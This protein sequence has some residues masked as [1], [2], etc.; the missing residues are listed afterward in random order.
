MGDALLTLVRSMEEIGIVDGD[1][2][3]IGKTKVVLL[4]E[5]RERG[6]SFLNDAKNEFAVV[7]S[8]VMGKGPLLVEAPKG[9]KDLALK[10]YLR[11]L[12]GF[13]EFKGR[14]IGGNTNGPLVRFLM[15]CA[16]PVLSVRKTRLLT[17]EAARAEIR[18]NKK[19]FSDGPGVA[20]RKA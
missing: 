20:K 7:R 8:A 18:E 4:G 17:P 1:P 9:R 16:N 5:I 10:M 19:F 13:W 2:I 11:S 14:T 12:C 15:A 3:A 6:E